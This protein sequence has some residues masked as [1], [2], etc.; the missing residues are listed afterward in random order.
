MDDYLKLVEFIMTD[1]NFSCTG[2]IIKGCSSY[3][4]RALTLLH[5]LSYDY[6]LAKLHILYPTQVREFGEDI[7]KMKRLEIQSLV[8]SA[9][10]GLTL[11]K[12][13]E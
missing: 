9:L 5:S 2:M 13:E 3:K 4:E 8:K 10:K 12:K 6:D 11:T 1:L 7:S